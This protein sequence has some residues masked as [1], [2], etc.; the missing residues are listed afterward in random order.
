MLMNSFRL[1]SFFIC[2]KNIMNIMK[3]LLR[4]NK[5]RFPKARLF[6]WWLA[7]LVPLF[8]S[9]AFAQEGQQSLAIDQA[10]QLTFM[11]FPATN[12]IVPFETD[13]CSNFPN[14]TIQKPK[15]WAHCCVNHDKAYWMGGSE[16]KKSLADNMLRNCVA[17]TGHRNTGRIMEQGVKVFGGPLNTTPYRWGYGW[18]YAI[19]YAKPNSAQVE[20]IKRQIQQWESLTSQ[21]W[22]TSP[23]L[24]PILLPEME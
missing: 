16:A 3:V 5:V 20:S 13:L 8:C 12:E 21:P 6:Q 23:D 2:I 14:G 22:V 7:S 18:N 9:L 24:A 1:K 4:L 17:A 11:D 15:L 19:G 10:Q